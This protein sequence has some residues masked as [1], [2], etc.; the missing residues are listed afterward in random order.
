MLC[1]PLYIATV[2]FS[3]A[4]RTR[5]VYLC[6]P[7]IGW[8]SYVCPQDVVCVFVAGRGMLG[9]ICLHTWRAL[10]LSS[11]SLDLSCLSRCLGRFI[12]VSC[13]FLRVFPPDR[14]M[15]RSR[16]PDHRSAVFRIV[17]MVFSACSKLHFA[18]E[19]DVNC[20]LKE[21]IRTEIIK[22]EINLLIIILNYSIF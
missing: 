20:E 7:A 19:C 22:V 21:I 1:S 13:T 10:P 2:R 6:L 5:S 9:P 18:C 17:G 15:S 8:P 3:T 11:D 12:A 4:C 14:T 16:T